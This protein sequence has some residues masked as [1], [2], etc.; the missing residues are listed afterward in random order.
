MKINEAQKKLYE[1]AGYWNSKTLLDYWNAAVE[2]YAEREFVVDDQNSRY[3][4]KQMDQAASSL[5]GWLKDTG[6]RPGE[7]VTFQFPPRSEF[8]ITALACLKV[9]AILAPLGTCFRNWELEGLLN[10]LG[11]K[12]HLCPA[13][14][15]GRDW[16]AMMEAV[17]DGT[18]GLEQVVLLGGGS[19]R[20]FRFEEILAA[21]T[22]A[23]ADAPGHGEDVAVILC[24][25]GTTRGCKAVMLTHSN[26]LF[27]ELGF[28]RE[29]GLSGEDIMFMPAPLSHA[30]GFH[31]GIVS[32][33]LMGAKLV[34]QQRFHSKDAI[35]LMTQEKCTYSMGAT[36]FA[37]DIL[38]EL[39]NGMAKP[40]HLRF[41]LCGGAPVPTEMVRSAWRDHGLLI[42]EVYGSTESVPHVFVR[43]EEALTMD[44]RWSGRAMEG[45]EIRVVDDARRDVPPGTVGEQ[46]SRGPNVFV[47]YLNDA[48]ATNA[49][50]D[51]EGWYYSGDLC[52]QDEQGN[53]RIVGRKKDIIM[54]GGENLNSNEIND[55]ME[56]CP[57]LAD[58]AVIGMPDDRLGERI[59][60]YVV[61]RRGASPKL[62]DVLDYLE[63]K[64]IS[65]RYWPERLEVIDE[66]PRT[67]SGKVRKHL[68]VEDV[69][70]RMAGEGQVLS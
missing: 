10:L 50:L 33:M 1:Q 28:N 18:P 59:C 35:D 23:P 32:P 26:I 65:K 34:L 63:Q 2:A 52:V 24:T 22:P 49:V 16:A 9:G 64:Q 36:A 21:R 54:R 4:Y 12:I 60:A 46:A 44:G 27:S 69:K 41:Y 11:S 7:V 19:P 3:T 53:L 48:G 55:H 62:E 15:R 51:N 61:P 14:H 39:K 37:Y 57:G 8:V 31:H 17:R 68:L 58:H 70:L 5:A 38:Q 20:S 45:V 29:I 25:S 67:E 66:I 43:P 6:V 30:T 56:G 42:C 40:E 47:G 13:Q